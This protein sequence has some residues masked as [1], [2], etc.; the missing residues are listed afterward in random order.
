MGVPLID[1]DRM[2]ATW[3]QQKK[4]VLCLQDVKG[5][6]LYRDTSFIKKGGMSLQK[7]QC[8]RGSMN[9]ETF[10]K[11]LLCLVPGT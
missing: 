7:L 3:K 1:T 9:L 2:E 11:H 5:F 8:H 6:Q 10:H 4:H